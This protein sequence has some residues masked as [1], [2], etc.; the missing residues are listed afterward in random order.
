M[1]NV[2]FNLSEFLARFPHLNAALD[3]GKLTQSYIEETYNGVAQW[4]G[5][6][7]G[8]SMYPYEPS[9]GIYT[10]KN[11]LYL[12]TCH[13]LSL[14]LWSPGQP[15]R[16]ASATQGSV[17]TSFDLLKANSL[18]GQWWTQTPCGA[19]YWVQSAP[20]RK[21]GRVYIPRDYHPWG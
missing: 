6:N 13:L 16:V 5:A 9:Q 15:G 11:L 14:S 19:Q 21:G 8:D 17:S 1:S 18:V 12:A 20:Y 10:R 2:V 3:E 4:L 7:D